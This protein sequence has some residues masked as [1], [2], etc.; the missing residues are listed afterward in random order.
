ML[1][2]VGYGMEDSGLI[3]N[4]VYNPAGAFLP[5]SQTALEKEYKSELLRRHNIFSTACT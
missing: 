1:N 2:A 5:P 3:L 4:L